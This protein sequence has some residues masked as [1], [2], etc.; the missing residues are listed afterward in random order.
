MRKLIDILMITY[1]RS[2]Y[3]DLSLTRLLETCDESMRVWVWHNGSHEE[4]LSV[5][6]SKQGHPNFYKFYHSMENKKLREP[7]NWLWSRSNAEYFSKV[8]DDCLMPYGWAN[9][10]RKAHK[11]NPNFGIIGCWRFPDED[12]VRNKA[13]KKIVECNYYHRIMRNCWVEGSGYLMKRKCVD[14]LGLLRNGQSFTNYGIQL[15]KAGFINGWYY[16]F[17]YQEHFDDPRS[18]HTLLKGDQDIEQYA[19]LSAIKNGVKTID[20]WK[21]LLKQEAVFLQTCPCD[22]VYYTGWR[23]VIKKIKIKIKKLYGDTRIWS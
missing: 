15:E 14:N 3:T 7:T 4:T 13:E 12:F 5:V 23:N 19:P 6:R 1:N 22:Y 8:D 10:L 11:D 18:R 17:L 21:D 9:T 2:H 20:E 16:P